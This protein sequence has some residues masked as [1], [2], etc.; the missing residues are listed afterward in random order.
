MNFLST[1]ER[2]SFE[3]G[4]QKGEGML[5]MRLLERKFKKTIPTHYKQKIDQASSEDLLRW[6][7]RILISKA[8]EDVFKT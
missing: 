2:Q 5:L 1:V 7:D 4:M 8:L 3:Q 6:G